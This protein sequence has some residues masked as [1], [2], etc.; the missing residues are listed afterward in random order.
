MGKGYDMAF[1]KMTKAQFVERWQSDAIKKINEKKER[2]HKAESELYAYIGE[3]I[4]RKQHKY[5]IQTRN[6]GFRR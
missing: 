1:V 2:E 6:R 3:S 5:H 4:A